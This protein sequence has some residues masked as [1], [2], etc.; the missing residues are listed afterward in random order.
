MKTHK[1]NILLLCLIFCVS[2]ILA[3]T[4]G[5]PQATP[6]VTVLVTNET[7]INTEGLEFSPTFYE[8][9]IV[10]ISTNTAG[11]KK[12]ID[13]DLKLPAMSILLSRRNTEGAL[14]APEPFSKEITSLNHEGPVCFDRTDDMVYVSWK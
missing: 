10:F 2:G 5:Q 13:K 6:P 9:G 1:H 3:Q 8:D 14:S 4:G 12:A 7:A 11:L